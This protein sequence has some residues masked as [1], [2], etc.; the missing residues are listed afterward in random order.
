LLADLHRSSLTLLLIGTLPWLAFF[1]IF[2][3]V[4]KDTA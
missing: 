1:A 3:A 4:P 2:W